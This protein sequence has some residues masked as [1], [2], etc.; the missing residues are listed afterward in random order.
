[1]EAT[2]SFPSAPPASSVPPPH[3]RP[4]PGPALLLCAPK[5]WTFP[6]PGAR[7]VQGAHAFGEPGPCRAALGTECSGGRILFGGPRGEPGR[8]RGGGQAECRRLSST[9]PPRAR[10]I[11][12]GRA[13]DSRLRGSRLCQCGGARERRGVRSRGKPRGRKRSRLS[14]V[15]SGSS[16]GGQ[17]RLFPPALREQTR[18]RPSVP[19][20]FLQ[21]S[22]R[23][24]GGRGP[25]LRSAGGLFRVP[26]SFLTSSG[27]PV[28]IFR[29][30]FSP[31]SRES[32][33]PE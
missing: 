24:S 9:P 31:R 26:F 20:G 30:S 25:L 28:P 1:M 15:C 8:S 2:N 14:R 27:G 21:T 4:R 13:K 10:P 7:G 33:E 17:G 19:R 32:W 12:G 5:L 16:R 23:V 6:K 29:N 11:G 3:A 18:R 22:A